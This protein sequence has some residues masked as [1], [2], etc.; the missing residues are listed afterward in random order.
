[1]TKEGQAKDFYS[2]FCFLQNLLQ[3][4]MPHA[5][6]SQ[7]V[8]EMQISLHFSSKTFLG[9]IVLTNTMVFIIFNLVKDAT[10]NLII[11][12]SILVMIGIA[13]QL[14]LY[15]II[16]SILIQLQKHLVSKM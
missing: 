6:L 5:L 14:V 8:Q 4:L 10:S 11:V 7:K 3:M 15:Q 1:M 9:I 16:N 12:I 13:F 2:F